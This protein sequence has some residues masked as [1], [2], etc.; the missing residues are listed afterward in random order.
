MRCALTPPGLTEYLILFGTPLGT[1]GHTGRHPATDYFHILSGAQT[2]W[3]PDAGPALADAAF[4]PETFLPGDVHVLP[5]GHAKQYRMDAAE[6]CFALEYA[7]GWIPGMLGF[8]LADAVSSSWDWWAVWR[9][10][11]VTGREMGGNLLRGKI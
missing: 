6:G 4:T 7:R 3:G 2:A 11:V 5:R 8:G 10:V 1:E 9:T